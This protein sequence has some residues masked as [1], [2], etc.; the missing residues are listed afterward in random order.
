MLQENNEGATKMEVDEVPPA[1]VSSDSAAFVSSSGGG[2]EVTG[3]PK[4]VTDPVADCDPE[5]LVSVLRYLPGVDTQNEEVRKAI[6]SL[7]TKSGKNEDKK[8]DDD[9]SDEGASGDPAK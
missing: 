4:D 3:V 8:K 5:F 2:S 6:E 7:T 9:R 1:A